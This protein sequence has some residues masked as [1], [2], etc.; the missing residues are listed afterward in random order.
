MREEVQA[1]RR[2][3]RGMIGVALTV[4]FFAVFLWV[5]SPGGFGSISYGP[6]W[7]EVLPQLVAVAVYL[8]GLA[9]MMRIYRTSLLEPETSSWRYGPEE[10]ARLPD[11]RRVIIRR[12]R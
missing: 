12:V 11:K 1:A 6:I 4:P 2:N 5:A 8:T 10:S 7:S 9:W 3:A